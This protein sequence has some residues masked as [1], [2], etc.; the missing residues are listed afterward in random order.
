MRVENAT[1]LGPARSWCIAISNVRLS[2]EVRAKNTS[3]S[4]SDLLS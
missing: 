1:L 3:L 4:G 2:V